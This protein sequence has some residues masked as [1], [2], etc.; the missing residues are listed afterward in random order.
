M[1]VSLRVFKYRRFSVSKYIRKRVFMK[2]R[3][4]NLLLLITFVVTMMV[5]ITGLIVHKLASVLFLVLCLIHTIVYRKKMN[6]KRYAVLAIIFI[7]FLSG[8]F[9]MIYEELPIILALH[10]AISI[11]SV[12]LLA[13]HIFV[14]HKKLNI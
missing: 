1:F 12:F 14:Y 10:K 2:L 13:I 3:I 6:G 9:G 11:V 4:L 5:P 8:I 7:A